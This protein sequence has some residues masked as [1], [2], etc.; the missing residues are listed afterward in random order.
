VNI[1]SSLVYAIVSPFVYV[2]LTV[3]YVSR[4]R[5]LAEPDRD[6]DVP[7]AGATSGA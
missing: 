3:H 5:E 2:A 7:N 4:R 1:A 6:A